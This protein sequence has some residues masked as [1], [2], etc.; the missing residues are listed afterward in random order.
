MVYACVWC[1]TVIYSASFLVVEAGEASSWGSTNDTAPNNLGLYT[2]V[3]VWKNVWLDWVAHT[4][5]QDE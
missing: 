1:L 2:H 4:V 3:C 5:V